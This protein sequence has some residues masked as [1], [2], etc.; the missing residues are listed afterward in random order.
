MQEN[1]KIIV[2]PKNLIRL[3]KTR[4][5]TNYTCGVVALQSIFGYFGDEWREDRLAVELK[6]GSEH[7]TAHKDMTT[8]ARSLGYEVID[9][10]EW[11]VDE[12]KQKVDEGTPV[13][14]AFQ[15]WVEPEPSDWKVLWEDGHYA[16]V[17]GYDNENL[18]FMDPSTLGNYTYIPIL[19]FLDRWHDT[20]GLDN[21]IVNHLG[22]SFKKPKRVYDPEVFIGLR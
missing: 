17:I 8:F 15:A 19:E 18:F 7:G 5:S 6:S 21:T 2:A 4:Q 16:V 22:M 1:A 11:T 10:C 20:D 9:K 13:I 12:L 3:P 14:V